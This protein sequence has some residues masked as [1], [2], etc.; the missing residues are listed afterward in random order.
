[1]IRTVEQYLESLRDGRKIYCLGEQVEDVTRHPLTRIPVYGYGVMDYVMPNDPKTRDLYVAQDE[2]GEDVNFLFLPPKSAEDLVRRREIFVYGCRVGFGV[3]SSLHAMGV[4][5]LAA[6]T[7]VAHRVDR[8]LGTNYREHVEAY[9]KHLIKNDLGITGAIS[10]VKG[11]R[12]LRPSKQVQHKDF[13]VRIV[14]KQKDGIIVSGAKMHISSTIGANEIIVMPCR[15]HREED[16]DYAVVFST[17]LNAEG[18]TL[19]ATEPLLRE[20]DEASFVNF[21]IGA[22]HSAS[23]AMII[24]DNVFVPWERVYL[25]GEWQFSGDAA[26]MFGN[27]HRVYGDAHQTAENEILAGTAALMA[28]YN[29]VSGYSHIREKLSWLVQY[30]EACDIIGQASCRFPTAEPDSDLVYPNMLYSNVAKFIFA[31]NKHQ[32]VK[33]LQDISGGA[34]VTAPGWEDWMNPEVRPLMEKYLAGNAEYP[35]E[36]RLRALKLARDIGIPFRM[37]ATIHGEGS[38]AAQKIAM[39]ATADFER[40]KAAA[41]RVCGIPGWEE[42]PIFK[43]MPEYPPKYRD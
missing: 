42:H 25:C 13:Y 6:S 11:N 14:D 24:F 4:D 23:E 12:S 3:G 39:Y 10:D 8:K 27:F 43:E 30:A 17:P 29:G 37:A 1:L 20:Q 18:V 7:I 38:L 28:D 5:A 16:K 34:M 26:W 31:D 19:I 36:Y 2:E 41:K 15:T 9:R 40:Y 33:I 35:T 22:V 21:P 32:S